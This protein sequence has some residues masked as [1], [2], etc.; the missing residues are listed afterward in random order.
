ME[1]ELKGVQFWQPYQKWTDGWHRNLR[2]II[3]KNGIT[4]HVFIFITTKKIEMLGAEYI[5]NLPDLH[6][7]F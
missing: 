1:N 7:Y 5:S 6:A 4:D 3:L 2:R